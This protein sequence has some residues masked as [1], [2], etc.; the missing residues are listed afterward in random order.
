MQIGQQCV[1]NIEVVVVKGI[2][3]KFVINRTGLAQFGHYEFDKQRGKLTFLD[4]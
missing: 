2:D 4:E 3:Y 1:K